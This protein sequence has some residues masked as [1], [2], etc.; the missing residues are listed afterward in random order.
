MRLRL[1]LF[2][3]AAL[4]SFPE[5]GAGLEERPNVVLITWNDPHLERI[6]F[7]APGERAVTPELD[8]LFARGASFPHGLLSCPRGRPTEASILTGRDAQQTGVFGRTSYQ[9]LPPEGT[10]ALRFR[11]AGYRT[12]Y[13]GRFREG[14]AA[15]FGFEGEVKGVVSGSSEPVAR[16][17][18]EHAG[19]SPLFLWWSPEVPDGFGAKNLDQALGALV[20]AL[21][22]HGELERT[23]FAFALSGELRGLEFSA[24]DCAG[25]A[26]RA[27]I[28]LAGPRISAGAYAGRTAPLDLFPT[29]LELCGLPAAERSA[30]RSLVPL[31]H[32]GELPPRPHGASFYEYAPTGS[33]AALQLER[34][35][36]ALV[37]LDGPWK[38]ALFLQDIGVKIDRKSELVQVERTA[39]EQLLFDLGTD[40]EEGTNLAL[41]REHSARV[42]AL[43]T[44][45][46]EWWRASGGP[47]FR[48]PF[49]PPLL[50]EPPAEPRPNLVL[51]VADDMDYEHLG[52]LGNPRVRTPTLDELAAT[53]VVFPVAHV[54]MSRC[55]PSL[56]ALLSGRW[57]CQNGILDNNAPRTLS[58]R[59]S[60]PNQLK[61]AGYATFQGGKFWEGSPATMGFLAPETIDSVFERFV[62]ESQDELFHFIDAH[63]A[64]R[65]LF[66]WWAPMLPHGPFDPPERH[67]APFAT[68]EIPVPPWIAEDERAA[69]LEAERTAYAM[70]A[71]FD[72][73]LAALR[74]KLAACG[75]LEDTLFVFLID[76]G[77]ANGFPSK[78]T[79]FEKGLRTPIVVSWPQGIAGGKRRAELASSLDL[80]R[81]LLDYAGVPAPASAAGT[82]LRPALEG[83][84]LPERE[85]LFGAVFD[86]REHGRAQTPEESVYALYAR[87]SRWK[88][89]HYLRNVAPEEMLLYHDFVPF[90]AAQ[91]GQRA[92]YDLEAD[93]YEQH[94][95]SGEPEHAARLAELLDGAAL[96]WRATGGGELDL[97][98]QPGDAERKPGRNKNP[99]RKQ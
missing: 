15:N 14:L 27:P 89:V 46:L 16:F 18:G 45:A 84:E 7:L 13:V 3:L 95:L 32:G 44:A 40:P 96:W 66:L 39:G 79:V 21:E 26:M 33:R 43:R 20:D 34:N 69:F 28:A 68:C 23:L 37:Y 67:R 71:W 17:V 59:D 80:Y 60:L 82:S 36:L 31:L 88:A 50:G 6:G 42:E 49:L 87:T 85:T 58:G 62:R 94:D 76:N 64:E 97:G 57:P 61:A 98:M 52:F 8:A 30:G 2:A 38:Y 92:L 19:H 65:P 56:A 4:A 35:L 22:A 5:A 91:R 77:Y 93:P 72:E 24:R 54:P 48:L 11:A 90:P 53:G 55:R 41:R 99:R 51:V 1:V 70:G 75:E 63:H 12:L 47:E 9:N 86:Y 81:T 25:P 78:G 29:L 10:L 73:G 74:A 83:R